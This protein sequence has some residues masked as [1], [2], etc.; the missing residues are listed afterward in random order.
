[1][2]SQQDLDYLDR[3]ISTGNQEIDK[4]LGGGI[5]IGSLTIIEGQSDSGKSVLAQQMIWGSLNN[6]HTVSMITTE[7]TAKSLIGQMQS[8]NLDILDHYLL[9]RLKIYPIKVTRVKDDAGTALPVLLQTLQKQRGQ[10]LVVVDSLTSFIVNSL[11]EQTIAFFEECKSYCNAGMAIMVVAHSYAFS[12]STLVRIIS[13]CDAHLRLS[14]ENIGQKLVKTLEV[15]KIRG[16][17]M[18]TGTVV[19]FDVE[20]GLG[21]RNIP[22]AR[23]KV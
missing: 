22:F 12:E 19:T 1:V 3:V 8:L 5:P 16:A 18:S 13:M 20:P 15:S 4:K 14:T 9:G 11:V 17:A 6:N 2:T 7:N 21:M 23:A 10:R